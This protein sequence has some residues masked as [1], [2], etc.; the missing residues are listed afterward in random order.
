M[1]CPNT[2]GE[3]TLE[4]HP[5]SGFRSKTGLAPERFDEEI[6]GSS[7]PLMREAEKGR[8]GYVKQVLAILAERGFSTLSLEEE[9][10]TWEEQRLEHYRQVVASE[11]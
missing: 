1:M 11:G 9:C 2:K 4:E 5:L 10:S 6:L 7:D 8:V 3:K